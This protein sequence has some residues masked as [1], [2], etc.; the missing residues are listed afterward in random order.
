MLSRGVA[1]FIGNTLV[2]TLPGSTRGAAETMDAL[3]PYILHIFRV[4]E[5]MRHE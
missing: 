2:L 5:G 3:F 1:G 4:A